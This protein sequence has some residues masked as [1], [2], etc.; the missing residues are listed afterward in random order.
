V[1]SLAPDVVSSLSGELTVRAIV[2]A[3]RTPIE[4]DPLDIPVAHPS[5]G[6]VPHAPLEAFLGQR[7]KT[8]GGLVPPG[9]ANPRV[10]SGSEVGN[11]IRG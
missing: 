10:G 8:N 9:G 4:G 3:D 2:L 6:R 7:R 1:V 5:P 11:D